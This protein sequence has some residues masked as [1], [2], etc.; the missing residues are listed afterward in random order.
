MLRSKGGPGRQE[1]ETSTQFSRRELQGTMTQAR[2]ICH[3]PG[4]EMMCRQIPCESPA[5][6]AMLPGVIS[7]WVHRAEPR[8][9]NTQGSE[10]TGPPLP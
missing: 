4:A 10:P 2:N 8:L 6:E 5:K 7:L 1:S 3:G 9:T